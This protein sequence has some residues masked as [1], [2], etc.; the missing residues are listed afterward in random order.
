MIDNNGEGRPLQMVMYCKR[1]K[2]QWLN[3]IQLSCLLHHMFG[4]HSLPSL[5][6]LI[7]LF[8]NAKPIRLLFIP[9]HFVRLFLCY[10]SHTP[11]KSDSQT[12]HD[13]SFLYTTIYVCVCV[14]VCCSFFYDGNAY[15]IDR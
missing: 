8:R 9:F 15:N 13:Y 5:S 7:V 3:F 6:H 14:C 2:N 11:V 12:K 4:R 10:A 1:E